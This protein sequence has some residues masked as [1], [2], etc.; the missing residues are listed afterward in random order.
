MSTMNDFWTKETTNSCGKCDPDSSIDTDGKTIMKKLF[1]SQMSKKSLQILI[2]MIPFFLPLMIEKKKREPSK[3][4]ECECALIPVI[5]L[6]ILLPYA[7]F[8]L[9]TFICML[10]KIN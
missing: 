2:I 8:V 6:T 10:C 3:V 4:R 7:L 5:F 9:I 1:Y